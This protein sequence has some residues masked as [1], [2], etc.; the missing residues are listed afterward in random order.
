MDDVLYYQ[1]LT[2]DIERYR[3]RQAGSERERLLLAHIESLVR[4]EY[5]RAQE[6]GLPWLAPVFRWR[7]PIHDGNPALI[8]SLPGGYVIQS[9]FTITRPEED[10]KE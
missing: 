7:M 9:V 8:W 4:A 10:W 3:E 5:K 6:T 2:D 1:L